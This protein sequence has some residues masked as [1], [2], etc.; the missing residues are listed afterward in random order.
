MVTLDDLASWPLVEASLRPV[1]TRRSNETARGSGGA[2]RRLGPRAACGARAAGAACGRL[3]QRR[4]GATV[5][6]SRRRLLRRLAQKPASSKA[7]PSPWSTVGRTAATS[8]C[9]RSRRS[10]CPGRSPC[11]PRRARP[12]RLRRNPRPAP[13]PIVFTTASNPVELGLVA[14]LN[15]P[16]GNVTGATQLS[17]EV[18]SKRLELLHELLPTA[19]RFALLVNPAGPTPGRDQSTPGR[20]PGAR[21][22]A[23]RDRGRKR[24]RDRRGLRQ[25]RG[26]QGRRDRDRHR[27]VLQHPQRSGSRRSRSGTSCRRST[28]TGSSPVAGGLIGYGGSITASYHIAGVL[29]GRILKGE[30]PA[31][32]PVAAIDQDRARDQSQD[33][34]GARPRHPAAAPRPRRR[35]DRMIRRREVLPSFGREPSRS[36]RPRPG[37]RELPASASWAARRRRSNPDLFQAFR[38][39]LRELG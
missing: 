19:K 22:R 9:R 34:A 6:P 8:A 39:G 29:T 25:G 37:G 35:G 10:W 30:K 1:P 7:R 24:A 28:N 23:A 32:L 21:D 38:E 3:S 5:R 20:R 16:G 31:D 11:W 4:L 13:I 27:S 17:V 26:A 12:P 36:G 15:Q 14:S 2:R 18:A 33:G